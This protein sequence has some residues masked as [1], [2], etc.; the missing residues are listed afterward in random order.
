MTSRRETLVLTLPSDPS[1]ARLARLVSLHFFRQNGAR[2]L[3]SRRAARVVEARCR[4]LLRAPGAGKVQTAPGAEAEGCL[5]LT[6]VSRA[7]ALEAIGR[8]NGGPGRSHLVRL[9]R[10]RRP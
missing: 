1:L 9:E 2:M 3:E 10:P 8:R 6:L 4:E 7:R 5:V